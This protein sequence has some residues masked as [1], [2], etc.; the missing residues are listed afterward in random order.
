M[1]NGNAKM[2]LASAAF[3]PFLGMQPHPTKCQ[4]TYIWIDV[5][6]ETLR[7]KT[8]TL[9]EA[10]KCVKDYPIWNH[11]W[12]F[13]DAAGN[14]KF[15]EFYLHPVADFPDPFLG[16]QNRLVL[17]EIYDEK[18]KPGPT[19]YRA[20][21][22]RVMKECAAEKPWFGME[23]EYYLLDLDRHPLGWPK[24]GHPTPGTLVFPHAYAV[25]PDK[26]V[27]REIVEAHYRACLLAGIE[28]AG[29]NSEGTPAQWEFQ[30]G[31][32]EGVSMGDHLWMSRYLLHRT[33]EQF[34]VIVSLEPKMPVIVAG[35]WCGSG[36]HTNFSTASM[37]AEG[38]LKKI[39]EAM[40]KLEV[41]HKE[42]ME[43]YGSSNEKRLIGSMA[44]PAADKFDWA[45]GDRAKSVRIPLQVAEEGKGYFED[46]RPGSNCDPYRVT[47]AIVN[48]TLLKK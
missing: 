14:M 24:N 37:R 23:Q 19:N 36:C 41:T 42:H 16:G 47:T 1:F 11:G 22:A 6:G 44:A 48:S 34:G 3:D 39:E 32:C 18:K 27:G 45:V 9:P 21:C 15:C 4:A 31:P 40:S 43:V 13:P 12:G 35:N 7:S 20:E 28:I 46:R 33:A 38:G 8:K 17:C 29:T 30:I 10:P 26:V 25:G 5:T 2:P